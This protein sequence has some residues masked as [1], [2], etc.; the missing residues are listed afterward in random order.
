[1]AGYRLYRLDG[2]GRISAAEWIEAADDAA[3]TAQARALCNGS[4]LEIWVGSRCVGRVDPAV[5]AQAEVPASP[6]PSDSPER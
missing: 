6:R 3:A 5:D 4:T 2:A 1:M